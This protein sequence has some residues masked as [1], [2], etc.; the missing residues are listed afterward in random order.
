MKNGLKEWLQ[1]EVEVQHRQVAMGTLC[2]PW[3]QEYISRITT[4]FFFKILQVR[5]WMDAQQHF[6]MSSRIDFEGYMQVLKDQVMRF[7][8]MFARCI[9]LEAFDKVHQ[10]LAMNASCCLHL[11][12]A[13]IHIMSNDSICSRW[14]HR[15]R[16]LSHP[17]GGSINVTR[18][19]F[20]YSSMDVASLPYTRQCILLLF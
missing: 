3:H 2:F 15:Q 18:E 12:L 4:Y 5:P 8:F 17:R 13:D 10:G 19:T 11:G 14:M 6:M 1:G 16:A 9:V 20:N 7:L